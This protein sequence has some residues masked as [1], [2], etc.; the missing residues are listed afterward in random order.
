MC[1]GGLLYSMS[2]ASMYACVLGNVKI[3]F[4]RTLF[5]FGLYNLNNIQLIVFQTPTL[6]SLPP[7]T[8]LKCFLNRFHYWNKNG[9]ILSLQGKGRRNC[10]WH[11]YNHEMIHAIDVLLALRHSPSSPL[12]WF[13][14]LFYFSSGILKNRVFFI[15]IRKILY[16]MEFAG[17]LWPTSIVSFGSLNLIVKWKTQ[18]IFSS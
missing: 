9:L 13:V 6:F 18:N 3:Y 10:V 2:K 7:F 8:I 12:I 15:S 1:D 11:S 17:N 4:L 16:T 14:A 5:L